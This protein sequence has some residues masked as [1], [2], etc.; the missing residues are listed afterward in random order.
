MMRVVGGVGS[1]PKVCKTTTA[2]WQCLHDGTSQNALSHA[3]MQFECPQHL[4]IVAWL[5]TLWWSAAVVLISIEVT[6]EG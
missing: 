4:S 3:P 6:C 2:Q 5:L 1:G